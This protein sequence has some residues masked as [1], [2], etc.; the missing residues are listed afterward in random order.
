MFVSDPPQVLVHSRDFT[1]AEKGPAENIVEDF[2]QNDTLASDL[3]FLF[4]SFSNLKE[5]EAVIDLV[6][7]SPD[8]WN[9]LGG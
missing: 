3:N 1:D 6:F 9:V 8:I 7:N 2:L 4:F 5:E